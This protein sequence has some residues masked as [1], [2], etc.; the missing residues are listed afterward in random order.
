MG[1]L[2][3][4]L[5]IDLTRVLAGP[6]AALMLNELGARIIKVEP[7]RTGDDSRHIGPFVKT[8]AGKTKSGYFMSVNRGKESI[9]LDLKA[10][11]D[12]KIFEALLER[13][14]VLIENYRGGTM[15]KLGY[16]YDTLKDKYPRLVYCG[17][18]GF[19]HTGP[20]ARRPAY[21]M[22]VQ[23]MGGVMSL[24]GHP[25]SPPTRVGTSTGDLSAGLFA[26]IGMI[27]ALYD[28]KTTGR[29][30]KVD[31]SMLDSQVALLEN[32]I[33]RYVA[34]GEVPGRLGSRHPSIAPFA[35]FATKDG[36]IAIAAGNDDL[37]ARVA[38]VIGREDLI[39]DERFTD[40]PKRVVNYEPLHEEM[41][42]A[43]SGKPSKEWLA[44]LDAAG[45]PS[46]PL[47]NVAQVMEDPQVLARN[48]IIETLDPELGPIRM[49]GNPV[50][51][52]AH[53]DPKTRP[54]APDLDANRAAIL[55]ELGL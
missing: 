45:V 41:E 37:F 2:S 55:K 31:I 7:P 40:N 50:K 26:T 1:P 51:L 52:S 29:G 36:H 19:G 28:R 8:P 44:L 6:Y 27:A 10:D 48:M 14:D 30:Q 46:G 47:N 34:T 5:V 39:A 12:R 16:G 38:R 22:V 54:A 32:A 53:E 4:I 24:T 25:D 49:Q 33:S 18:S 9:A 23:A 35:A 13:A 21:D 11:G 43:L 15:E 42:I 3:G 17:V 20:Y